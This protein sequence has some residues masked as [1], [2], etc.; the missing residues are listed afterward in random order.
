MGQYFLT[1]N[2]D[3]KEFIHP[4]QLGTGLK[5][6][7]QIGVAH[8]PAS[9]LVMLL[10]TERQGEVYG[11]WC[12]DRIAVV[13]DYSEMSDSVYMKCSEGADGWKDITPMVAT[14]LEAELDVK[15]TG[16]G[17]KDVEMARR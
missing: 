11:R 9:A 15:Y 3:K 14:E 5:L 8:G 2:L 10:A 1:C 4:H 7:E 6:R 12:G 17:W 13:G 16:S